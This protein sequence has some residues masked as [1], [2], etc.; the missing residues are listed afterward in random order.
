MYFH[1]R[2]PCV[3]TISSGSCVAIHVADVCATEPML[4]ARGRELDPH[5]WILSNRTSFVK[6]NKECQ[7]PVAGAVRRRRQ[8]KPATSGKCTSEN[9]CRR[10]S[11]EVSGAIRRPGRNF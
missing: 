1:P 10:T 6:R 9:R 5:L 4:P 7:L 2:S 8:L 3:V 11:A